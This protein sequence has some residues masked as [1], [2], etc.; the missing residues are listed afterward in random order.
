LKINRLEIDAFMTIGSV[1]IDLDSKGLVLIQG[2][3]EDDSS[4][5]SNGA[6]KSTIV[7]ALNWVLYNETARGDSGDEIVN[8]KIKKNTRVMAQLV[9]GD[10]IYNVIRHRKHAVN[11]N[12][13]LLLDVTN[14]ADVID[15]TQ[16]TDKATQDV[17]TKLVGCTSEVFRAAIYSGQEAH[18]DLPSL[19]DKSLKVIVEEAA[20]IDKMQDAYLIARSRLSDA[21]SAAKTIEGR[22]AN[23]NAARE[24]GVIGLERI[25]Q[26][27]K[28]NTEAQARKRA[29]TVEL[30]QA[31]VKEAKAIAA[32][33]AA[34]DEPALIAE[35][36]EVQRR[37]AAVDSEH[38]RLAE[39]RAAVT[40]A[41]NLVN[42]CTTQLNT[43][44]RN[45]ERC[46]DKLTNVN[47]EVGSKCMSCGHV[48]ETSD[49]QGRADSIKK[50]AHGHIATARDLTAQLADLNAKH[51][52]AKK[53]L[54]DFQAGMT[55]LTVETAKLAELN[56]KIATVARLQSSLATAKEKARSLGAVV[57]DIDTA[58]DPYDGAIAGAIAHIEKIDKMLEAEAAEHKSALD[59]V[60]VASAVVE[61]FSPAGVRAHI[62]DTVTPFLNDRTAR[63]LSVLS[64]GNIQAAWNTISTTAKGDL[65]EK[66]EIAVSSATGGSSYRSLS[67]GEKRKVR[68]ATALALQDLVSSRAAKPIRLWI[69]DEIDDA[70]DDAGLERLMT[71]LEEKAKEKGTVLIISHNPIRDWVRS[72]VTVRKKDGISSMEGVLCV[73]RDK[74][75]E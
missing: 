55:D 50:D 12:R 32:E 69:G 11:K 64:D 23:S 43:E 39:L 58:K 49:V 18:V 68:L 10:R 51:E 19:T 42:N 36:D 1:T 46:R 71:V 30:M 75:G 31:K 56:E 25:R 60:A 34:F 48:I 65:R 52:L 37:I 15:M 6:G 29:E 24:S 27:A 47:G 44:K 35:R 8:R 66:F 9:D 38:T 13:V 59:A 74:V 14:P 61:V 45:A 67:G 3:N 72:H 62:L 21:T 40:S 20:G 70:L 2:E 54:A 5:I 53:E 41:L 57:S 63:Y 73:E 17:I 4:Q 26:S 7:E 28:E 33:A 16:G 22:I